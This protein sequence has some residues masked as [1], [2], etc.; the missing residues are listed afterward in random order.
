MNSY[1][2]PKI[3]SLFVANLRNSQLLRA[4]CASNLNI[5]DRKLLRPELIRGSLGFLWQ[6]HPLGDATGIKKPRICGDSYTNQNLDYSGRG[7]I[8]C[9]WPF[10]AS[11]YIIGN[12]L[13]FFKRSESI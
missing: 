6:T 2:T 13:S 3:S 8:R 5:L 12:S 10:W 1:L 9:L 11:L 7:N 4:I